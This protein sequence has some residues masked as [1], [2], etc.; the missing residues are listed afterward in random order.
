MII[1]AIIGSA[2]LFVVSVCSSR[3]VAQQSDLEA[4]KGSEMT[5]AAASN[6]GTMPSRR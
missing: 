4:G 5:N 1:P 3:E 6:Y 2:A